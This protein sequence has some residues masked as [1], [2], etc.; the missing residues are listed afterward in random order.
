MS[1]VRQCQNYRRFKDYH[2]RVLHDQLIH[3][4]LFVKIQTSKKD[5][6]TL[7]KKES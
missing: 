2:L 1:L 5:S 3:T 7:E 4:N 6:S